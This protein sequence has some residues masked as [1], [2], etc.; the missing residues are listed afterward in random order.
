MN[1]EDRDEVVVVMGDDTRMAEAIAEARGSILKFIEAFLKPTPKQ[2]Y[3]LLKVRFECED[4]IEHLWL[5]DLDLLANTG[6]IANEPT[7]R[8]LRL[9]QRVS[10]ALDDVT[11]WMFY[12]DGELVGAFTTKLL[13]GR[14][15]SRK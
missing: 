5:A 10:F 14:E 11:D 13:Q 2:N 12:D 7:I 1:S 3:F 4:Q 15:S 8:S 9:K 6:L